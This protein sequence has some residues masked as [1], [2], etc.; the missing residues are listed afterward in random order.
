ML[1]HEWIKKS[2]HYERDN[3]IMFS[4][5]EKYKCSVPV[6]TCTHVCIKWYR[7]CILHIFD[8]NYFN[9]TN[10]EWTCLLLKW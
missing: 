8:M 1:Y 7:N 6:H 4:I 2:A 3:F 5:L 10:K 9:E